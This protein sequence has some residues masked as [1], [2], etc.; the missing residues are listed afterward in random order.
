MLSEFSYVLLVAC[1]GHIKALGQ[2]CFGK[3]H[4]FVR[5]VAHD[6]ADS[7]RGSWLAV[8]SIHPGLQGLTRLPHALSALV[9]RSL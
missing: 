2:L 4:H 8:L 6:G 9:S 5:E 3:D 1:P 7:Y